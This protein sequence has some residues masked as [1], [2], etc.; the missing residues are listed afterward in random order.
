MRTL[1]FA[2]LLL[3]LCPAMSA[4][5][6]PAPGA[7]ASGGITKERYL[8]QAKD[9]AAKRF[10]RMDSNH[11]GVLTAGERRAARPKKRLSQ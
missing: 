7:A 4:A 1:I 6:S 2:S 9:R 10:D 8:E 5:Q 3:V 11:D